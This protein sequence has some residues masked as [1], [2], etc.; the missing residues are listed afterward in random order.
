VQ[1]FDGFKSKD[2]LLFNITELYI[3]PEEH[4]RGI[5]RSTGVGDRV[6]EVYG[7]DVAIEVKNLPGEFV[8]VGWGNYRVGSGMAT[9]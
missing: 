6:Y 5:T 9:Y 1:L 4:V 3:S 2:Y 7:L 8:P